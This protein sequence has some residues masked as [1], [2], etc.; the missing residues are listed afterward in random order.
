MSY[1]TVTFQGTGTAGPGPLTTNA[2][3]QSAIHERLNR[4]VGSTDS[5]TVRTIGGALNE[6]VEF[7][8]RMQVTCGSDRAV[9]GRYIL[10]AL[11]Q[12]SAQYNYPLIWRANIRATGSNGL[13]GS[14]PDLIAGGSQF[15][16]IHQGGNLA[17]VNVQIPPDN[18]TVA[19]GGIV[20]SITES[21][22]EIDTTTWLL[23]G[24]AAVLILRR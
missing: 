23:I 15:V 13:C 4:T 22:K 16:P 6:I 21:V 3:L 24:L 2:W 12:R 9:I 1:E 7:T 18:T 20:D 8:I 5:V 10:N 11:E 17:T 19:T 14:A